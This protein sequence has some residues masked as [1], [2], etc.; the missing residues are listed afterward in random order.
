MIRNNTVKTLLSKTKIQK[1]NRELA[2]AINR[3]YGTMPVT[4]VVITNGALI[5]AADLIRQLTFPLRFDTVSAASYSGVES[6][7]NITLNTQLKFDIENND[8][9][10]IDDILDTG[11]T[12]KSVTAALYKQNPKS[13]KTCVLL[14]KDRP[15]REMD[16]ADFV[17]FKIPDVF[18]VGYGLDY[19]EYYRNLPYVGILNP[20]VYD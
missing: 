16:G 4:A 13:I 20:T 14:D 9:L 15:R 8:I 3:V 2:A 5:F 11:N 6:S 7:T 17:G 18:V 19:N 12:L 1:R 10:I